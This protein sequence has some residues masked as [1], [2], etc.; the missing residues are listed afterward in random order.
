MI[1]VVSIAFDHQPS[2]IILAIVWVSF[3]LYLTPRLLFY[4]CRR[5]AIVP[6]AVRCWAIS[7]PLRPPF[8]SCYVYGRWPFGLIDSQHQWYRQSSRA[9]SYV[10]THH[11]SSMM[12]WRCPRWILRT[13]GFR[14]KVQRQGKFTLIRPHLNPR[15]SWY[16][17]SESTTR[18][19]LITTR[20]SFHAYVW[21]LPQIFFNG[22]ARELG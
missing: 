18:A 10:Y 4:L 20:V 5:D 14:R 17:I 19:L 22:S 15:T 9:R 12:V 6:S 2:L 21:T 16:R 3:L 8:T 11:R 13:R 1:Y 7:T